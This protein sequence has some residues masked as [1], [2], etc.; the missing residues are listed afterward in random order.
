MQNIQRSKFQNSNVTEAYGGEEFVALGTFFAYHTSD[1]LADL[2][3]LLALARFRGCLL[4][5]HG[6]ILLVLV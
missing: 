3:G 5:G 4:P 1:A 6:L 2:A